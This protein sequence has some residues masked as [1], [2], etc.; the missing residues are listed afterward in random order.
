MHADN[1]RPGCESLVALRETRASLGNLSDG[2]FLP[3]NPNAPRRRQDRQPLYYESSTVYVCSVDHLRS[4]KSLVSENWL[5]VEVSEREAIDINTPLD[6]LIAEAI[7]T[8][9]MNNP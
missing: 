9:E 7:L 2:R 4:T 5:G 1:C 3:L 6:F 8:Y